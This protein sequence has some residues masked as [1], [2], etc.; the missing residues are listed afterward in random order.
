VPSSPLWKF[1]PPRLSFP[2]SP[3]FPYFPSTQTR[4]FP[5]PPP[6]RDCFFPTYVC[7]NLCPC[8][9]DPNMCGVSQNL[10]KSPSPPLL[11]SYSPPL[12]RLL[13]PCFTIYFPYLALRKL[14]VM[15][16]LA[17]PTPPSPPSPPISTTQS[18]AVHSLL[19]FFC[20]S[21][22]F[23]FLI[24]TS[25]LYFLLANSAALLVYCR[26]RTKLLFLLPPR[27]IIS[28]LISGPLFSPLL[29]SQE[30][31]PF[32]SRYPTFYLHFYASRRFASLRP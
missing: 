11:I 31:D 10:S 26:D 25:F 14:L 27:R 19:V 23:F 22:Q 24:V 5:S 7:C 28:K 21:F 15:G 20:P 29:L 1:S 32:F 9:L 4:I 13:L 18:F 3:I 17:P 30:I 12:V 2:P 16:S 6:P 8:F